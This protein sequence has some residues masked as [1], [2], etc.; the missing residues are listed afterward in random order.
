MEPSPHYHLK[1]K[2]CVSGAADTGHCSKDALDKAKE[3]GHEIVEHGAILVTGATTG[4]PYWAARGAKEANGISVGLSPA[5]TEKEHVEKYELPLDFMDMIIYTGFGYPGRNL[6]LT[7][8]SDAVIVGCGRI[9]T[10]NE[11]TIAFEDKKPIGV[12]LD[13]GGTTEWI[14]E[15]IH[16]SHR[17]ADTAVVYDADPK[18]LVEKVIELIKKQKVATV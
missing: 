13:S 15:L 4:F 12:L 1:Y 11:F 8:A 9:G 6:M 14:D 10:L 2:I 7:R 3:L 16:D 5:A 18:A 17:G